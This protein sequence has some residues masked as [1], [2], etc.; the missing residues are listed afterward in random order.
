[1]VH[2]ERRQLQVL[3]DILPRA[4]VRNDDRQ[5]R[6]RTGLARLRD[7]LGTAKREG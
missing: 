5:L 4:S 1:M 3:S 6:G 7:A 2:L